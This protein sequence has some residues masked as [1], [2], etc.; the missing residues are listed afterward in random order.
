VLLV[1]A[2]VNKDVSYGDAYARSQAEI[3]K[4]IPLAGELGIRI[5]FENVWNSFLLSPLETARYIDEF[6]SPVVGAYFDVG[7]VVNY[8]WPSHWVQTLGKRIGKLDVKGFSRSIADKEGKY[9]GFKAEIS[10]DDCDWAGVAKGLLD[11]GIGEIWATAEVRG[12]NVDRL[13]DIFHR[14]EKAF[15]A[16]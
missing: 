11:V 8:G 7:N 1:P 5:L 9:A 13:T 15:P 2:V 3:R 6:E 16:S 10:E 12:G 4:A 14:M